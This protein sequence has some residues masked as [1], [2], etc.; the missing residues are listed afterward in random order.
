ME[1]LRAAGMGVVAGAVGTAVLTVAERT[2]MAITGREPSTVP[3][4]VGAKL[5]GRDIESSSALVDRLNP[6]VHWGH[7]IGMGAVRGILSA[8]GLGSTAATLAYFPIVFGGD[9]ALYRT[10]G[11]APP[12]WRWT[13]TELATD[14][15]GKGVLAF[16]TSAAYI[17]LDRRF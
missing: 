5:A 8:S 1:M 2:E 4:Q 14:L 11:I 6:A 7:G 13:R 9:A 3:G 16:A 15:F 17:A 10:L 12:P